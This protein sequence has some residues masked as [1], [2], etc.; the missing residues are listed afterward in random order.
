MHFF[1]HIR[2]PG[3]NLDDPDG[4]EF[5]SLVEARQEAIASI[6]EI[7]GSEIKESGRCD[8]LARAIEITAPDG[9]V[10]DRVAFREAI[11]VDFC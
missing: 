7:L 3:Q 8:V 1:L 11:V 2:E 9:Q 10:H 5:R 6:R 4:A